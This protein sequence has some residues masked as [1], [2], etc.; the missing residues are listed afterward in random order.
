MIYGRS[1]SRDTLDIYRLLELIRAQGFEVNGNAYGE[2]LLDDLAVQYPA[3]Y[4]GRVE[5]LVK[6][7]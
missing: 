5:I 3:Q 4:Y 7:G 2:Y 6:Y 1:E